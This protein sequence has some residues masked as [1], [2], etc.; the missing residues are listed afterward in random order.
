MKNATRICLALSFLLTLG[1]LVS[2]SEKPAKVVT[3]SPSSMKTRVRFVV[4][5]VKVQELAR[6]LA[7][8]KG[9]SLR[10]YW[11]EYWRKR[12]PKKG[13]DTVHTLSVDTVSD[14]VAVLPESDDELFRESI[15]AN[16]TCNIALDSNRS[17]VATLSYD[18]EESISTLEKCEDSR[19][20]Y[21]VG[22]GIFGYF[23]G[24]LTP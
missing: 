24:V 3:T 9:D 21:A 5:S 1:C 12:V 22:G 11:R 17:A 14:T 18:L 10:V 15:I 19:K 20:W 4:D 7:S 8:V 6:E 13:V 16:E 2:L 23:L